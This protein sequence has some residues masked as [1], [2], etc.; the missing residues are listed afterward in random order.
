MVYNDGVAPGVVI[1][2]ASGTIDHDWSHAVFGVSTDFDLGNNLS[3]T[4]AVYYQSSWEDSVNTEDE[5]WV[6]LS[7]KYAF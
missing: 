7:M 1:N 6:S 5:A 3:F 2:Q 4:P